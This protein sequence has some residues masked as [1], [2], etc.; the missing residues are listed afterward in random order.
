VQKWVLG[1]RDAKRGSSDIGGYDD[2][3]RKF[4]NIAREVFNV[5]CVFGVTAFWKCGEF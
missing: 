1:G 3:Q 4:H 5:V 2:I